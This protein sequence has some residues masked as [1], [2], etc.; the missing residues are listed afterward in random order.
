MYQLITQFT[1]TNI[2]PLWE[3]WLCIAIGVIGAILSLIPDI[4]WIGFITLAIDTTVLWDFLFSA[5][6]ITGYA[7]NT[8]NQ[9]ITLVETYDGLRLFCIILLIISLT[10]TIIGALNKLVE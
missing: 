8:S 10:F 1:S 2:I 3:V 5:K 6:V 7:M 9:I 4:F